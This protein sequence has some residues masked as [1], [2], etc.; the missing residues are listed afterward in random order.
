MV[1]MAL[2]KLVGSKVKEF[3]GCRVSGF[4]R[5]GLQGTKVGWLQVARF[6]RLPGFPG[7]EYR[8]FNL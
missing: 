6:P 3:Q 5:S 4:Q 2:A 7:K 8:D 1:P